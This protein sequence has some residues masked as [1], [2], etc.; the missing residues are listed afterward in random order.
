MKQSNE[1]IS[2]M[3]VLERRKS[4][5]KTINNLPSVAT[6]PPKFKAG[7]KEKEKNVSECKAGWLNFE[8]KNSQMENVFFLMLCDVNET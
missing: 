8:R 2:R 1:S 4:R 3:K 6:A 5:I 7:E